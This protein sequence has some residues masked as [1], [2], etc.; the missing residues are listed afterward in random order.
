[1]FVRRSGQGTPI[2]LFYMD[3]IIIT[4]SSVSLLDSLI[5]TLR[6]EFAMKDLGNLHYFLGVEVHNRHLGLHLSQGKYAL[7][8]L[9]K[10]DM[11]DSKSVQTPL[12]TNAHLSTFEGKLLEDP[13]NYRQMVGA[14]QY[15]TF[16]K[17]D[18]LCCKFG[19]LVYACSS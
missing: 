1:M 15:L 17:P 3:D 10:H 6:S 16:T 18:L 2:L 5:N 19:L 7:Q 13:Y 14:L 11:H 4:G 9:Q 12:A 8:L